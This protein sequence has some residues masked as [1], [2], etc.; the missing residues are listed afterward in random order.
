MT[1]NKKNKN[2]GRNQQKPKEKETGKAPVSHPQP[3]RKEQQQSKS[4]TSYKKE[5]AAP[6]QLAKSTI[7]ESTQSNVPD[8]FEDRLD[9]PSSS[10]FPLAGNTGWDSELKTQSSD[11]DWNKADIS[12]T[13]PY[14]KQLVNKG[15]EG[16]QAKPNREGIKRQTEGSRSHESGSRSNYKSD[17]KGY[18]Q[19]CESLRRLKHSNV[20]YTKV[21][22]I[23]EDLFNMSTEYSLAHCV[24]EDMN[25]GSGIAVRFSQEFKRREELYSQRQRPGGL[26][27]LEDKGRYIYYL[28]TKKESNGKPTM[29]TMWNSLRKL[30]QHIED[31]NVKQLAIPRI[32][33]G[34]DRLEWSEVKYLLECIFQETD[35]AITVCNYQQNWGKAK[36][37]LQ[38]K[39]KT[40]KA[41]QLNLENFVIIRKSSKRKK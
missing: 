8:N 11:N 19:F 9:M 17:D 20:T 29:L 22:E 4:F 6:T 33:C 38:Q 32:G 40:G 14:S 27:I 16:K 24:A 35:V 34:L 10:L 30:R 25:M 5:V 26:A 3:V 2:L 1:K 31:N 21:V 18:D 37:E 23:Q 15:N 13:N 36:K 41:T 28:V 7:E 39:S 12:H